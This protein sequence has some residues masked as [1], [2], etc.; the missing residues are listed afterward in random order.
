MPWEYIDDKYFTK[1]YDKE[2]EMNDVQIDK[3]HL[4]N[5][6]VH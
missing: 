6:R 1:M 3:T 4:I 2:T 5:Q